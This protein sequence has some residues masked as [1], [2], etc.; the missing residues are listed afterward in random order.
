[1]LKATERVLEWIAMALAVIGGTILAAMALMTVISITGRSLIPIGLKPIPG[2]F[3][4]VEMGCAIAVFSFLPYCQL[5]RGHVTVDLF[6]SAL[7]DRWFNLTTLL[8]DIFLTLCA[9][10]IAWRL[11]YGLTDQM[12]YGST[13]MILGVPIWWGYIGSIVGAVMFA[14]TAAF[15]VIRDIAQINGER[16]T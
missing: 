5:K 11:Y 6:V 7:P 9:V 8:G 16:L 4:L 15:T 12:S 1:M 14:V 13:T 10:V 3:E 2:D